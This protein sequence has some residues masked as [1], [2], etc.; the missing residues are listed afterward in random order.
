MNYLLRVPNSFSINTNRRWSLNF[1]GQ[2]FSICT[3]GIKALGKFNAAG[4]HDSNMNVH[5]FL[6]RQRQYAG[7]YHTCRPLHSVFEW[8]DE[9]RWTSHDS[10]PFISHLLPM[11]MSSADLRLRRLGWV[12]S[13]LS[14]CDPIQSQSYQVVISNTDWVFFISERSKIKHAQNKV[15]IYPRT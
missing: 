13:G 9:W 12:P 5:I 4:C 3:F 2:T 1:H 6:C 8:K 11:A 7:S 10:N 14:S 15:T